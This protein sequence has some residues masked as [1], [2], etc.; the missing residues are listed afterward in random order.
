MLL[1]QA[2]YVPDPDGLIERGGD[3]QIIL[4]MELS[5]HCVVI[6]SSH[7]ANQGAVL[8][9]PNPYRLIIGTRKDPWQLVVE[10]DRANIVQMAV[11]REQT[12]PTLVGP[13]F[14]LVVVPSRYKQRLCLVEINAPDWSIMLLEAIDQCA[15]TIV[16]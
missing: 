12:P 13:Y 3:D 7:C 5:A 9:V 11:E 2:R 16:P 6:M 8:P 14:D 15:H 4:G 1:S 10:E